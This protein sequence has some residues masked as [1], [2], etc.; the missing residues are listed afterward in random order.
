MVLQEVEQDASELANSWQELAK[1]RG[2]SSAVFYPQRGV[3][4][5]SARALCKECA[6]KQECLHYALEND[7][8]FG[9]WGG[10]S[11]RERRKLQRERFRRSSLDEDSSSWL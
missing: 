1:C 6:V 8:R 7:E 10:L 3:P 2:R 5:A 11:E 9:I 4:T